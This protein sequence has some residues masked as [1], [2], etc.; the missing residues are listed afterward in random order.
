MT[1]LQGVRFA[2]AI[3]NKVV[4][5]DEGKSYV[6]A[7]SVYRELVLFASKST[8]PQLSKDEL[9]KYLTT[10]KLDSGWTENHDCISLYFIGMNK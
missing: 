5:T 7:Q 8:A 10:I 1:W 2:Y 4:L 9:M 6:R 3:L